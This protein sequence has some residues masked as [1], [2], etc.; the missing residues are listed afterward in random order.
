MNNEVYVVKFMDGSYMLITPEQAQIISDTQNSGAAKSLK[1]NNQYITINQVTG[2][3]TL[4]VFRRNTKHK[5]ASK[6]L[7]MCKN[8]HS[9]LVKQDICPCSE[10]PKR[11]P[12]IL[13]AARQENPKLAAMLNSTAKL[14]AERI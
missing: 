3:E 13:T 12:D 14:L 1:I 9:I 5:L 6:N 8:C 7:R 4:D 2:I 11:F 10:D